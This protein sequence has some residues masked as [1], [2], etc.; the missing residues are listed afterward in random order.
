MN[1]TGLLLV[2]GVVGSVASV[3]GVLIAAPGLKSKFIHLAY[4]LFIT[5][6]AT[7]I[8]EFQHRASAT[9]RQ[10]DEMQRV[11]NEARKL[12]STAERSTTGSMVGFMLASLSFLE[13][14]KDRLPDTYARAVKL[15]EN[16][17]C[18]ESG[19]GREANSYTHFLS[20]QEASGAMEYLLRGLAAGGA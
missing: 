14:F 18:L 7:G 1:S 5:I 11:E 16:S 4:A 12:L 9:Q 17:G 8:V 3:I 19:Y 10:L 6:L 2:M 20:M 13:K 15:C